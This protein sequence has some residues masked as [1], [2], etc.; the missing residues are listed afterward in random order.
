MI[1]IQFSGR[2]GNLLFQIA[3]TIAYAMELGHA[4]EF[5]SASL[6]AWKNS[7]FRELSPF[8]VDAYETTTTPYNETDA[9]QLLVERPSPEERTQLVG[10]FQDYRIFDK[11]HLKFDV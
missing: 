4:F 8:I 10:F 2:L 5:E 9:T 11:W 7:I 1:S 6:L 3:A